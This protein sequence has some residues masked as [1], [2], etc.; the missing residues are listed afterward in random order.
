MVLFSSKQFLFLPSKHFILSEN[1]LDYNLFISETMKKTL[2]KASL[3]TVLFSLLSHYPYPVTLI[4]VSVV[5]RTMTRRK[6]YTLSKDNSL[7]HN[8]SSLTSFWEHPLISVSSSWKVFGIYINKCNQ[9]VKMYSKTCNFFSVYFDLNAERAVGKYR[10]WVFRLFHR[11]GLVSNPTKKILATSFAMLFY[12]PFTHKLN[13]HSCFL[14]NLPRTSWEADSDCLPAHS[15]C[16]TLSICNSL[17][18]QTFGRKK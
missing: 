15:L 3:M 18:E 11:R 2:P 13:K 12:V 10:W 7:N 17:S 1:D 6:R 9:L 5:L 4:Y 14:K 16:L 8:Y